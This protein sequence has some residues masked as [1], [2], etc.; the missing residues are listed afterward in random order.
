MRWVPPEV[1]NPA[2]LSTSSGTIAAFGTV[3]P[4]VRLRFDEAPATNEAAAVACTNPVPV[5]SVPVRLIMIAAVWAGRPSKKRA[6]VDS[7][8]GFSPR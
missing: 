8:F 5:A 4:V 7:G 1:Y 3:W 6:T 2:A